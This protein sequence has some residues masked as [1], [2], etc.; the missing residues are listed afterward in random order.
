MTTNNQTSEVT[1]TTAEQSSEDI[2]ASVVYSSE[3][4]S[5]I[6]V[7]SSEL[8]SKYTHEVSSSIPLLNFSTP[9]DKAAM[10]SFGINVL[11]DLFLIGKGKFCFFKIWI[12]CFSNSKHMT[13]IKQ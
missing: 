6:T 10:S 3:D 9:F 7:Q 13:I 11:C 5:T 12:L 8:I 2:T 1:S 4:T